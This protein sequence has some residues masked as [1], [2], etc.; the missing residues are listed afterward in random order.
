MTEAQRF[1]IARR[2][3]RVLAGMLAEY[4]RRSVPNA[5]LIGVVRRGLDEATT[6][7][8]DLAGS[9]L[10]STPR[11]VVK[12]RPRSWERALERH[13]RHLSLVRGA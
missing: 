13:H 4:Q 7:L 5:T 3:V 8:G 1:E 9:I 10:K 2:R 12:Q 6:E 11:R